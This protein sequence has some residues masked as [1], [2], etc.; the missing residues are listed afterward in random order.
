M[1]AGRDNHLWL[2]CWRNRQQDF[3]QREVN[4]LLTRFWPGLS[5]P[6]GSRIFVPLCGKSLDMVWLAEQGHQVI[7][8]EL[9]PVAV[10]AFFDD[11][12][13]PVT[14]HRTG[15]F[16]HWKSGRI[17]ILCGDYFALTADDIGTIDAIYD[18]AA[19]TALPDDIRHLY[20]THQKKLVVPAGTILLLTIEDAGEIAT[21]EEAIGVDCEVADLYGATHAIKIAH[22][23]SVMEEYTGNES[24]SRWAE[25][26]VYRMSGK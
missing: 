12:A 24:G 14:K 15:N 6:A 22:V 2:Q 10:K 16:T 1:N 8:V 19:L 11:N 9:S 17:T 18:R 13:L 4:P 21:L 7:G 25:Y 23:E 5:L 20:I 3:H 26:K